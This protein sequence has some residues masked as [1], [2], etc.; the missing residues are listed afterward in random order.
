MTKL[1]FKKNLFWAL[2]CHYIIACSPLYKKNI[3]VVEDVYRC[4]NESD[5]EITKKH[6]SKY[7]DDKILFLTRVKMDSTSC[8]GLFSIF[9]S[10]SYVSHG[11]LV[12]YGLKYKDRIE[13]QKESKKRN[14]VVLDD[15]FSRYSDFFSKEQEEYIRGLYI[16]KDKVGDFR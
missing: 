6:L 16:E 2:S 8:I 12:T 13:F 15:F 10:K 9:Y 7:K 14:E 4:F 5:M 1:S 3:P 11:K